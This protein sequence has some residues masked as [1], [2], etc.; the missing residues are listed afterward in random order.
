MKKSGESSSLLLENRKA[1]FRYEIGETLE[2][3]IVLKGT[4]VKS[5]RAHQF[6]FNDSYVRITKGE[7]FL[8]GF[9]ISPY[10]FGTHENHEPERVRKLLAHKKEIEKLSRK[11]AEK[12]YTLVPVKLYLKDSKVKV[13][14]GVARGKKDFDKRASIKDRDMKKAV[15][16]ELASRDRR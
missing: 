10:K 13:L 4:E 3:G 9:H 8:A 15:S 2:C 6:S 11:T 5:L 12:G 1:R 7:L 14:V 16:R